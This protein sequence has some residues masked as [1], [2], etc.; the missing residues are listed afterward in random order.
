MS[1]ITITAGIG[2][3]AA[4]VAGQV[5]ED[6]GLAIYDDDRMQ[7]E[8]LK[9]GLSSE[10]LKSLDEKAPGL[11]DRLL[12][13]KPDIYLDLMAAVVYEVA[14]RGEGIIMGHGASFFLKDFKCA[15]HLRL[16]GSED[17]RIQQLVAQSGV[18]QVTAEKLIQQKDNELKGFFQFS[19]QMDWNDLALYD[20]VIN[21]DKMG[22]ET[23]ATLI[24]EIARTQAIQECSL[25]ALETMEKLS[26]LKRVETAV[27]KSNISPQELAI[28]VSAPGTVR[29]TGLINPMHTRAG[30]TEI[31]KSVPG[32]SKVIFE[33]ERHPLPKI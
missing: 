13:R 2:C 23:V 11:L 10:D 8:A 32:V 17:F 20:M 19:F 27:L 21:V 30:V 12:L 26:L 3:G 9:M 5:A 24:V 28:E 1:L 31:V 22:L 33:A 4:I 14:R 18:K 25:T 15:L 7:E 6:L 16:H 29:I